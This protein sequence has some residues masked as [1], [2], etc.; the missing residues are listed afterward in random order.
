MRELVL[1]RHAKSGWDDPL[2]EDFDRPLA[3]RGQRAAP[4]MGDWLRM[5][6]ALPD[7]A[8]VSAATRTRETW[9]LAESTLRSGVTP[10]F[11]PSLYH[12]SADR[13]LAVLRAAQGTRV[14]M[15]GHNPGIAEL[16]ALLLRDPP[17]DPAFHRFPTCATLVARFAIDDWRALEPGSGEAVAFMVPRA[18]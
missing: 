17:E 2:L 11:A 5:Q 6:G 14:L 13:M 8:L 18:L 15:L 7:A 12:A 9:A 4:R 10:E 16:A 1:M 3:P